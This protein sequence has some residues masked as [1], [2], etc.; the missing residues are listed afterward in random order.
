MGQ[1]P[2]LGE[3]A[4]PQRQRL[5]DQVREQGSDAE[6]DDGDVVGY[7]PSGGEGGT[8]EEVAN[9]GVSLGP[10]LVGTYNDTGINNVVRRTSGTL[11]TTDSTHPCPLGGADREGHNIHNPFIQNPAIVFRWRRPDTAVCSSISSTRLLLS[12]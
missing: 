12:R 1:R 11:S 6:C 10:H 8:V 3:H 9:G 7:G 4:E 5:V 2:P